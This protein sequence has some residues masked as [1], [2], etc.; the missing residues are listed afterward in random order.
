MSQGIC[1][2][3]RKCSRTIV[4]KCV[5]ISKIE[6]NIRMSSTIPKDADHGINRIYAQYA[7]G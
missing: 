7:A 6:L 5:L 4:L 2:T 1:R 3:A